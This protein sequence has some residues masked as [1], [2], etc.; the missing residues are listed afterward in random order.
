MGLQQSRDNCPCQQRHLPLASFQHTR[1]LYAFKST[2][3]VF[4]GAASAQD[5]LHRTAHARRARVAAHVQV[6]HRHPTLAQALQASQFAAA[7][8]HLLMNCPA[9]WPLLPPTLL[10]RAYTTGDTQRKHH[11]ARGLMIKQRGRVCAAQVWMKRMQEQKQSSNGAGPTRPM[12]WAPTW[13][14]PGAR[15]PR[16]PPRHPLRPP[17]P[18]QLPLQHPCPSTACP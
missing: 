9:P 10:R 11:P 5:C 12:G 15:G 6:P 16:P 1:A 7:W 14:P 3:A 4:R 17:A 13:R 18:A 2:P 8:I